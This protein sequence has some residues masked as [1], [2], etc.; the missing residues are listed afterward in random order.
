MR[1]NENAVILNDSELCLCVFRAVVNW[2]EWRDCFEYQG[3]LKENPI[4]R[5]ENLF[6][7]FAQ[8]YGLRW[9]GDRGDRNDFRVRLR[10]SK[11]FEAAIENRDAS[12]IDRCVE[13]V[14]S[15]SGNRQMSAVS[16]I[17]MFLDPAYFMPI[18]KFAKKGLR[19]LGAVSSEYRNYSSYLDAICH[20][21]EPILQT[22]ILKKIKQTRLSQCIEDQ[23]G[24]YRRVLDVALMSI[25]G[26]W[27]AMDR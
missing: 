10:Q 1:K 26:R 14:R 22:P 4:L 11:C 12:M 8:E 5:D 3:D 24:F 7:K 9:L 17:A 27:S 6:G 16:K 20:H 19:N 25:G 23:N 18:D 21:A 2:M 15:N 13:D